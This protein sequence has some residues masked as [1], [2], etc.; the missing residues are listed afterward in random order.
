MNSNISVSLFRSLK[1]LLFLCLI[2][3]FASC[4]A[5]EEE[6]VEKRNLSEIKEFPFFKPKI[7]TNDIDPYFTEN[8]FLVTDHGPKSITRNIIQDKNGTYWFA[9]WN[10]IMSYDGERFTNHTNQEGLRRHRVF[11]ILE[12]DDEIWFGTIGAGLYRYDGSIFTNVTTEDG[13]GS[14]EIECMMKDR[15]GKIWLGTGA[16]VSVYDGENFKNYT[17]EDGLLGNDPHDI[18]QDKSGKI[19]VGAS[20]GMSIYDPSLQGAGQKA[21]S[22]F[23]D[24]KGRHWY[25]VRTIIQDRD[26]GI[27]FGGND[28]LNYYQNGKFTNLTEDFVGHIH[29]DRKGDVWFNKPSPNATG[30]GLYVHRK[31]ALPLAVQEDNIEQIRVEEEMVFVCY[32]SHA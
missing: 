18:T 27:W 8:N 3:N 5:Q 31:G 30:V 24:T 15:D 4:Q 28:G 29:E 16:G 22:S 11:C 26:G 23:K 12:N 14:N 19:W 21:F 20:N 2:F 7:D 25:N 6:K 13:L 17:E 9:T 32:I 1:A 10:G